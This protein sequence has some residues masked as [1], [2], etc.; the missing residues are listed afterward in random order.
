MLLNACPGCMEN[1]C[2]DTRVK[3]DKVRLSRGSCCA[4]GTGCGGWLAWEENRAG[5]LASLR[6]LCWSEEE[7]I[8]QRS[9]HWAERHEN[10]GSWLEGSGDY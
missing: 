10:Y 7:G 2:S 1:R 8:P 9:G 5:D 6:K 3:R 4:L